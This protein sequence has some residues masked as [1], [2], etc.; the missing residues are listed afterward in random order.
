MTMGVIA[1]AG[2]PPWA[3]FFSKDEILYQAFSWQTNPALGKLLWLIGL[4]TAGMTSFYMFRLWYKAF[5]GTSHFEDQTN[6]HEHGA[7]VHAHRDTHEVQIAEHDEAQAGRPHPV[8][9]S[10]WIMLFPLVVLAFLSVV[11]G[12]V[13]IPVAL[14]GHNEIEHFLEPVFAIGGD[15]AIA[16]SGGH[17]LEL[18]LAAVSVLV[19]LGGWYVAYL[20]YYKKPGTAAALAL[21]Y[22]PVYRLLDHKYWVD[23]FYQNFLVAPLMMFSRILEFLFDQFIVEGSGAAAGATTRGLSS[24]LRR[25]ISGNIRSYAGWLA[26]GAAAVL[27]VMTYGRALW[28]HS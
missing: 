18:G 10:P 5:W 19:A 28:G 16:A 6:L 17:G 12:W 20:F 4:I 25:Q 24:L 9:E 2:I 14:G 23:E 11:G 21:R 15:K 13:G 27:L 26:F 22:K 8:H 1:I 7:A 3:G